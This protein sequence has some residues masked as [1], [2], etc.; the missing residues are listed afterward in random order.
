[1]F[2]HKIDQIHVLI[3]IRLTPF[4]SG[5]HIIS[6]EVHYIVFWEFV[7]IILFFFKYIVN[8]LWLTS[9]SCSQS[10]SLISETFKSLSSKSI[11]LIFISRLLANLIFSRSNFAN[12]YYFCF[13]LLKIIVKSFSLKSK[14]ESL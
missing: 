1:M 4:H 12:D 13:Q 14:L 3:F 8:V 11:W 7:F 2:H 6:R 9:I 10:S 5:I